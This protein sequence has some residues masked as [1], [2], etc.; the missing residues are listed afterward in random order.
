MKFQSLGATLLSF[1]IA[2]P[3]YVSAQETA[4]VDT[5][6]LSLDQCIAIALD[7]NPA[8]KIADM[9]IERVDYSKKEIIGQLLPSISF[10]ATYSRTVE[11]QVAY[12][13]M[14]AFKG[15][16]GSSSSG[17]ESSDESTT[18]SKSS[19]NNGIKMGLDNSYAMGFTAAMPIIAPQLWKTLSLSDTQILQ[20]VEAARK[21]RIDLINQ[22]K[23]AYYG[24]L[25]AEDSYKVILES[26]E[27]AKFNHDVYLKKYQVGTASEYDVLRSSVTMKNIEPELSQAEIAIKQARLQ[28]MILMGMEASVP[29]KTTT[30]LS[31]Y[32]ET[33]YD[34]TLSLS[35][36]IADNSDLRMLDLQTKSLK[37]AL[38][39][40]KMAWY[41]TLALTANY[42]WTSSTNGTPFKHINWNPYSVVGLTLSIPIFQ[43]GQRYTRIKQASIQVQEMKWQRENLER[44]LKMQVDVAIDNIQM[45]VKRIAST[46]E[47]VKQADKAHQI[48]TKSFEIGAAS[49]L[50]LRDSELALTRARLAYYQSIY[51]YLIA[52]SNLELLLGN[53]DIEKY[54]NLNK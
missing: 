32:E 13:N 2:V 18:T 37:D 50:D 11:K 49:Y 33:M 16:G 23:A 10:D 21:S 29:V 20:N 34:N 46:S 19:G 48:M 9:E 52:N 31:D 26:F 51:N 1:A 24:L 14:S 22:V 44:T 3:A 6:A 53:A 27:N 12:M 30:K 8:I 25:L 36:S 43:G 17:S 15:L 5:L 45:N 54:S 4:N 28:L 47:S 7:D 39:I 40:Q 35:R 42:N 38:S 41:P